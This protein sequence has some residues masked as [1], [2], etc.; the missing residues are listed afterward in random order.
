MMRHNSLTRRLV[1]AAIIATVLVTLVLIPITWSN[2]TTRFENSRLTAQTLLEAEY[3][4]LL[5]GMNE[6]LNHAL[7]IAEF[8]SVRQHLE[9]VGR[10]QNPYQDD[11]SVRNQEQLRGI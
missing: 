6:S 7:A 4:A 10:L 8:P 1:I 11:W 9:R 3:E 2:T 5:Q